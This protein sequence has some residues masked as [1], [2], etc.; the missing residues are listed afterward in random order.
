MR[1]VSFLLPALVVLGLSQSP[2]MA[3]GDPQARAASHLHQT[4]RV[5]NRAALIMIERHALGRQGPAPQPRLQSA[6]LQQQRAAASPLP[7]LSAK[8]LKCLATAIYFE[9]RGE[10]QSGQAAVAQVILNRTRNAAYPDTV[11]KVVYQGQSRRNACQFSF[12]CDG[13]PDTIREKKAWALAQRIAADVAHGRRLRASLATATHYH[14]D[15]VSPRWAPKLLR[16]AQ[17]GQHIFYYEE[18]QA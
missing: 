9:A 16:L 3:D 8:E 13:K 17:I 15:Y 1:A 4:A 14:A 5:P 6:A 11:C 7:A 18:R 10:S 12:A 2:V